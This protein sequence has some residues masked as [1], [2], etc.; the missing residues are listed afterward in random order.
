MASGASAAYNLRQ[1]T[2]GATGAAGV[3]SGLSGVARAAAGAVA[4]PFRNMASRAE[5]S[6]ASS[7]QQGRAAAWRATGGTSP[8]SAGAPD[9]TAAAAGSAGVASGPASQGAPAW[10]ERLRADQAAHVRRHAVLQTIKD[11]DRPGGSANP[12]LS[13]K[14]D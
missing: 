10:A 5:T 9:N 8:V 1:A 7:A 11:G 12:D 13:S 2:S 4:Q 6:L 3:A 14:E